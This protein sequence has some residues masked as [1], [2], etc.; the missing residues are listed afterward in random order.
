MSK[1]LLGPGHLLMPPAHHWRILFMGPRMYERV[2]ERVRQLEMKL[3]QATG[4]GYMRM[5]LVW[6]MMGGSVR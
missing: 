2:D 6:S 5:C 4:D 3:G 1:R